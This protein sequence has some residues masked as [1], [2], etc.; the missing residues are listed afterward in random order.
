[1]RSVL[2]PSTSTPGRRQQ[3]ESIKTSSS[4]AC[5]RACL[6]AIPSSHIEV[7]GEARLA[8]VAEVEGSTRLRPGALEVY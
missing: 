4:P 5:R 8:P 6:E 7:A 3:S 2:L 1:M